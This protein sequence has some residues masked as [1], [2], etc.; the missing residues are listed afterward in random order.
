MSDTLGFQ[1]S[2]D[3]RVRKQYESQPKKNG[4]KETVDQCLERTLGPVYRASE[5]AVRMSLNYYIPEVA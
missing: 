1:E 2:D 4:E 5:F 3:D